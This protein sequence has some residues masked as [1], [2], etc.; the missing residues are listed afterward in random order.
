[1]KQA[2]SRTEMSRF[3]IAPEEDSSSSN[4]NDYAYQDCPRKV[5]LNG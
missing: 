3:N 4:S 1:M 2:A 5:P